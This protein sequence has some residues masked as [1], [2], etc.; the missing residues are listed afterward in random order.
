MAGMT[1]LGQ[2]FRGSTALVTGH[3]G[4]KGA[5]L[6]LWLERLGANVIGY[7]LD[8]PTEPNLFEVARVSEAITDIRADVAD[9][10]TMERTI[11]AHRPSFIFHMAAQ[12]I[13]R[14]SYLEPVETFATN[15]MGLVNLLEAV[16]RVDEPCS[17]VVVTSDKCY[18]DRGWH[19]G[20]RENDPLGGE[21][22]PYSASKAAQEIVVASYRRSF[23]AAQPTVRVSS[24]RAG[25]VLGGGDWAHDRIV[26]DAI[27]ALT[28][29]QDLVVRNPEATRPW[30]HV[31]QPLSGYL[32]LAAKLATKDGVRFADGW[33]FGPASSGH[34]VGQLADL[35]VRAWGSGAWRHD[36]AEEPVPE[37]GLLAL[38]I[39]RARS[40]L[41]WQPLWDVE[42]TILHTV[43]WYRAFA[44]GVDMKQ[45]CLDDIVAFEGSATAAG[46]GWFT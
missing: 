33:N 2:T 26:P 11:R 41:G 45:R 25:N 16:R 12:P 23:F 6:S 28:A 8:P 4:F 27:R 18:A 10:D 24:A 40:Q 32:L 22:D 19:Y 1:S 7:A 21:S 20:Y 30:Q 35:V 42:T 34:S 13:V 46:L 36:P 31:L 39:D 37:A 9:I 44:N 38:A 17:V 3:T 5:W 43:S 15:V 29:G 14:T